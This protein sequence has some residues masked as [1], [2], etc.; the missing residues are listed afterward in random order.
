MA[1]TDKMMKD[2]EIVKGMFCGKSIAD[3]KQTVESGITNLV[4]RECTDK[5]ITL[6]TGTIDMT[7]QENESG[8]V[9]PSTFIETYNENGMWVST[10][11]VNAS[12]INLSERLLSAWLSEEKD[13]VSN[14]ETVLKL[15]STKHETKWKD[16]LADNGLNSTE[17]TTKEN[18]IKY[19]ENNEHE[20]ESILESASVDARSLPDNLIEDA[21]NNWFSD[22]YTSDIVSKVSDYAD[23]RDFIK[24]AIDEL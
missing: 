17:Q 1:I 3:I 21:V 14:V 24:D 7:F 5:E 4:I 22:A 12:A 13:G 15:I 18:V 11:C 19:I 8:S 10:E 2:Y 9:L 6:H 23:L 16:Y 20:L